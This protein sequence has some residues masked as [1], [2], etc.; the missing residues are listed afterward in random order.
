MEK[1]QAVKYLTFK[2]GGAKGLGYIGSLIEL[3]KHRPLASFSGFSGTSAG[4]ITALL[5]AMEVPLREAADLMFSTDFS[6]WLDHEWGVF[7]DAH[8]LR[9]HYGWCR[10]EVPRQ[11]LQEVV[12]KYTGSADSNFLDLPKKLVVCTYNT[13]T[14]TPIY[15]GL[16]DPLCPVVDAVLASMSIPVV[17]EPVEIDGQ[18]C[19]DG[20]L[21]DNFPMGVW[22]DG[23]ALGFWVDSQASIDW[24]RKGIEPEDQ[25]A[26]Q[27]LSQY[28]SRV[29]GGV[30]AAEP[31]HTDWTN[32]VMVPSDLDTLDFSLTT[33]QKV[34]CVDLGKKALADW[35]AAV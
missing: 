3:E 5:C 20:G 34:R 23:E 13:N 30:T 27:S 28:I 2:G 21:V 32:V 33:A 11:W 22:P 10:S 24:L 12:E 8:N 7:R 29:M 15:Y 4:A 17:W 6:T 16:H 35:L 26:A 14:G 25:G 9:V 19:V 1:L 18:L 31:H